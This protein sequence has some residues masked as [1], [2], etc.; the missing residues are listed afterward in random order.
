MSIVGGFDLHRRQITYDY[1]DTATG[2]VDR[3]RVA[4]ADRAHLREWLKRF[5]DK[6]VPFVLEGCTGWSR[7]ARAGCS[8]RASSALPVTTSASPTQPRRPHCGAQTRE[9]RLTALTRAYY[10]S[11]FRS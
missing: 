3:G 7:V 10:V 4:P 5:G 8:R 6:E 11:L 1:V 2:E 9:P